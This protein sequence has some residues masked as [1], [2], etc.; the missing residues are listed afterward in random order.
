[1]KYL[2]DVNILSNK[3]LS[4]AAKRYDLFVIEDVAKEYASSQLELQNIRTAGINIVPI[5]RKH[6]EKLKEV[7]AVHGDNFKLIRLYTGKGTG[8]VMMIAFILAEK[9]RPERLF[10]EE[11]TLITAD[12]ELRAVASSYKISSTDKLEYEA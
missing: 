1:M 3:L 5:E 9:E 7:L 2:L 6:L 11:Y 4:R 8:D 10:D 12:A